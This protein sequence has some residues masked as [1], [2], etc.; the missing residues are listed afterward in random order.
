[1]DP[2]TLTSL[3]SPDSR[4]KEKQFPQPNFMASFVEESKIDWKTLSDGLNI[5]D[6]EKEKEQEEEQDEEQEEEEEE[7][8]EHQEQ[9]QEQEQNEDDLRDVIEE[10]ALPDPTGGRE[11]SETRSDVEF[12]KSERSESACQTP[13]EDL[14]VTDL[15]SQMTGGLDGY[16]WPAQR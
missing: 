7:E 3:A 12:P 1:M 14:G 16:C 8:E 11:E 15:L 10:D 9:L 13:D 2:S 6:T 4:E 5:S